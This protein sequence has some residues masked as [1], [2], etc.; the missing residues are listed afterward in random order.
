MYASLLVFTDD[1]DTG[2]MLPEIRI[3][4]VGKFIEKKSQTNGNSYHGCEIG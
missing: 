4:I 1:E 3:P 2:F